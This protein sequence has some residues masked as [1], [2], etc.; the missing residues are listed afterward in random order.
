[1]LSLGELLGKEREHWRDYAALGVSA[2]HAS[3]LIRM[4]TDDA[5][6]DAVSKSKI[7]WSPVHAWRALA[8]VVENSQPRA[9]EAAS[10]LLTLLHRIDD[11]DDDWV[12]ED[13]PNA[14][15]RIGAP[16]IAPLADYLANKTHGKWA[17]VAASTALGKIGQ[18]HPELRAEC[19]ARLATQLEEYASESETVNGF[20]ISALWDLRAMESLSVIERA[21]ASGR[22]DESVNG[23][24]EDLQV[25]WG[26]KTAREHPRKPNSLTSMSNTLSTLRE[27][28]EAYGRENARLREKLE[29]L[30]LAES[31]APQSPSNSLPQP[32][33]A[34]PKIGRN[35][36]CPCGSGKKHK[37]CCGA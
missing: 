18:S 10:A 35:D 16:A 20:V 34:P 22:V 33:V 26:L 1:M 21:F 7:V 28:I 12:G 29:M 11:A 4:A 24:F 15:A 14:F 13:L 27:E 32:Y 37:K 23:D 30:E 2:D 31:I 25:D 17:R 3:D 5:L 8:Q 9:A 6:N 36:P 19:V